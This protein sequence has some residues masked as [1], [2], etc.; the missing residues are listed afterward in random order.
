L[1]IKTEPGTTEQITVIGVRHAAPIQPD[2]HPETPVDQMRA[3][4]TGGSWWEAHPG[5]FCRASQYDTGL[6]GQA[7]R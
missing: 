1:E 3:Y 7:G 6:D 5:E 2:P 4:E